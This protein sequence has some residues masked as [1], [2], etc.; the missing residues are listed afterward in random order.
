[1]WRVWFAVPGDFTVHNDAEDC[2][3]LELQFPFDLP[4]HDNDRELQEMLELSIEPRC[5]NISLQQ[6]QIDLRRLPPLQ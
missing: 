2:S 3:F 4:V 6:L 1:M 5:H